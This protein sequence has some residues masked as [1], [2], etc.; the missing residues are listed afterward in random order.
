MTDYDAELIKV[1]EICFTALGDDLDPANSA[2]ELLHGLNGI[3]KISAQDNLHLWIEFDLSCIAL[4]QLEDALVGV[5]Y[6]LDNSILNKIKRALYHYTEDTQL[7]NM[8]YDHAQSKSTTEIFINRYVH[9]KHGCRDDRPHYY[10][11]YN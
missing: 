1:R 2:A 5:G 11:H 3:L 10:R 6:H 4:R 7:A 9:R 8:G